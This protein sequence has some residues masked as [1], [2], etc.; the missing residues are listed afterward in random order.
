MDGLLRVCVVRS[1]VQFD[2]EYL[3]AFCGPNANYY[4]S[5]FE[6]I[7]NGRYFIVNY[8]GVLGIYWLFYRKCIAGMLLYIAIFVLLSLLFQMLFLSGSAT[9]EET[10]LYE[11]LIPFGVEHL[12]IMPF[13]V[14]YI[15]YRKAV[16]YAANARRK[17]DS[18]DAA[19]E[20]LRKS[21]GIAIRL[22]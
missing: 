12:M 19:K 6:K 22:I 10:L 1:N 11:Y 5:V 16:H 20:Y 21:G 13:I 15:Y 4:L 17:F 2:R 14:N 7:H 3:E 8:F 9:K 18:E